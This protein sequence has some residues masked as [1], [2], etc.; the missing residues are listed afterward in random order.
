[1]AQACPRGWPSAR[2]A[3]IRDRRYPNSRTA[4]L[5]RSWRTRRLSSNP[6]SAEFSHR[7]GSGEPGDRRQQMEKQDSQIAHD[8]HRNKLDGVVEMLS[9]L[10]FATHRV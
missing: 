4:S 2:R 8:P 7:T 10:E 3:E 1:M 9:N 5:L 6:A